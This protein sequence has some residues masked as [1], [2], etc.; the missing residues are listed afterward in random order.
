[1]AKAQD[2]YKKQRPANRIQVELPAFGLNQKQL[3]ALKKTVHNTLVS[4]LE[5]H[6]AL[7]TT[8]KKRPKV[9][10]KTYRPPKFAAFPSE[11]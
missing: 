3:N 2:G 6:E 4:T 5:Q 8:T 1:M 10:V 7:M 9:T 11:D